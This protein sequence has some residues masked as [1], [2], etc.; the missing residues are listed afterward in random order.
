VEVVTVGA[1]S[2][3]HSRLNFGLF[4]ADLSSGEL[5]RQG[6]RVRLQEQPFRILAML[7]DRPGE[8]VTREEVRKQ[9]WPDGTFVDFDEGLDTALKK[10]R[11]A[12][13]DSAQ[14]PTFIE[15]IPRR[16]YRFIAP[17]TNRDLGSAL[18]MADAPY[19]SAPSNSTAFG[20]GTPKYLPII[21]AIALVLLTAMGIY[22][23][24]SRS[25]PLTAEKMEITRLTETGNS[26]YVAIS[27]EGH[28]VVHA[29][30]VGEKQGL[31]LRQ[32]ATRSDVQILPL[33]A[34]AFHGLSFSPD[35][36]Y[37]YFLRELAD[38]PGV[39]YL[40]AMPA[41]GGPPRLVTKDVDS[42]IGFSPDGRFF[43]FTRGIPART[44]IEVRIANADGSGDRLLASL[45]G[46]SVSFQNGATWSPDGR[47]I[48][49][50]VTRINPLRFVLYAIAA[51]SGSVK[52]LYTSPEVVGRPLW[53][54]DGDGLLTVV[55]DQNFHGRLWT[56]SYPKGVPRLLRNDLANFDWHIDATRDLKTVA[57]VTNSMV[58]NIWVAA[59]TDLSAAQQI[60]TG[61]LAMLSVAASPDGRILGKTRDGKLWIFKPDGTE[62][63][64]LFDGAYV[65]TP[66][67]CGRFV[68]FVADGDRSTDVIRVETNGTNPT[69]LATGDV[70]WSVS[71][72]PD[73]RYVFYNRVGAPQTIWRV[74]IDGGP[75]AKV[76]DVR[77]N[78]MVGNLTV[79][80]DGKFLAYPFD[81]YLPVSK[82]KL[83]IISI[84][85]KAPLRVL[86]APGGI[87]GQVTISWSG[88]GKALQY[89][90]T[91]KGATN[92]WQQP[93]AG[94]KPIQLT[95]YTSG[96]IFRFNWSLDRKHMLF[97]RGST[98]SDVVLLTNLR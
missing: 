79:S 68:V 72:S 86:S 70:G 85:G 89:L 97:S 74:P 64:L 33:E 78:G 47:T 44:E 6:R 54:P 50:A 18:T 63:T 48:A 22:R 66:T 26:T 40:Y 35:G 2:N 24:K 75:S 93:V 14:N 62:R 51:N 19:S 8:V 15:T 12:L 57:A 41:L 46:S 77:E 95:R 71:C 20:I 58:S 36:N 23:W 27:P 32:V 81:E 3:G 61:E 92:V 65:E 13:G 29:S 10:L 34:T 21:G 69:A 76:A 96:K 56:I 45:Q 88:D 52:E 5:C 7:L 53:L 16:G 67:A 28:Y 91:L 31:W 60:T 59:S 4:E 98:T 25:R 90:L 11:Y 43:V 42:P 37:I 9:L 82:T 84:D 87:F 80:P 38:D 55:N 17:V 49:V 73:G 1:H 39:K 30:S 83:A 94:G